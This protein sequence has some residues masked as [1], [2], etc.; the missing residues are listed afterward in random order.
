MENFSRTDGVNLVVQENLSA[1]RVVK[2]FVREDYEEE[3]FKKRNDALRGTAE[4][5]FGFVT[6]R[7]RRTGCR[8][9][10]R[11]PGPRPAPR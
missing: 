10:P 1:I 2:S 6:R 8:V 5:A 7:T 11:C 3:K 4:R 9:R